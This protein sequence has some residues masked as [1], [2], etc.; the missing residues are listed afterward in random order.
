MLV[1]GVVL[2][3]VLST[4]F[5][6]SPSSS[7]E[8]SLTVVVIETEEAMVTESVQSP[9]VIRSASGVIRASFSRKNSDEGVLRAVVL[10]DMLSPTIMAADATVVST[11]LL[12]IGL[13]LEEGR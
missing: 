7:S 11:P 10:A 2:S 13:L 3:S 5:A 12:F 8:V 6:S 4:S 1:E 9:P